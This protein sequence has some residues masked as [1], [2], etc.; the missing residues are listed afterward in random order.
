MLVETGT[1]GSIFAFVGI[2]RSI[3][4]VDR[5]RELSNAYFP[6]PSPFRQPNSL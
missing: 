4:L 3:I 6:L 2:I 1:F 5:G